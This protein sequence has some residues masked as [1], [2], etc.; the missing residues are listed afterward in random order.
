VH[1]VA[2]Q[3]EPAALAAERLVREAV[4][5]GGRDNVTVVVVDALSVRM[6]SAR[7]RDETTP[8]ASLDEIEGDTL[9]RAGARARGGL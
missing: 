4:E 3:Q 8:T 6:R 2:R 5:A 7:D 1:R 9:P